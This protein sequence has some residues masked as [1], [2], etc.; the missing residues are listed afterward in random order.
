MSGN[1]EVHSS[2]STLPRPERPATRPMA[3]YQYQHGLSYSVENRFPMFSSIAG[4]SASG[5]VERWGG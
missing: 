1:V 5:Q 2:G 3:L 4:C